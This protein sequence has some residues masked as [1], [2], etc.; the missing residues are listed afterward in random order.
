MFG[1]KRCWHNSN[2]DCLNLLFFGM[3]P[4]NQVNIPFTIS[5]ICN[6]LMR[7]DEYYFTELAN[8]FMKI[9]NLFT[10]SVKPG[11]SQHVSSEWEPLSVSELG[12]AKFFVWEFF[13]RTTVF[14]DCWPR[15][16][17]L[18][19]AM[20]AKCFFCPGAASNLL[21]WC[22]GAACIQLLKTSDALNDNVVFRSSNTYILMGNL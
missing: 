17:R 15:K 22:H 7:R 13:R 18:A 14:M 9:E 8:L 4:S 10:C 5:D 1:E 6:R 11:C 16:K 3:N 2:I 19:C 12:H 21:L 20:L